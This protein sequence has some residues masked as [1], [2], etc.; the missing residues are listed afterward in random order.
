MARTSDPSCCSCSVTVLF[1][2]SC[3][4][5][6]ES[7]ECSHASSK[8]LLGFDT[9]IFPKLSDGTNESIPSKK[10]ENSVS[11]TWACCSLCPVLRP[12]ELA[13]EAG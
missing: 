6:W 4:G 11:D 5:W 10:L 1:A 13:C 12:E 9:G 8:L 3:N 7:R 2:G